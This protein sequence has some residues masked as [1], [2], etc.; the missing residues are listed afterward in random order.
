MASWQS[1][2]LLIGCNCG[3]PHDV[4][5]CSIDAVVQRFLILNALA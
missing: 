2:R 5:E 3:G 4:V 1:V